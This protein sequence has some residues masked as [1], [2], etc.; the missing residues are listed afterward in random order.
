MKNAG[1]LIAIA[2]AAFFLLRKKAPALAPPPPSLPSDFYVAPAQSSK[3]PKPTT[4]PALPRVTV[5]EDT[6]EQQTARVQVIGSCELNGGQ[7]TLIINQYGEE[8]CV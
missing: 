5:Y 2:A 8:E 6:I 7:G 1:Y 4:A 3:S